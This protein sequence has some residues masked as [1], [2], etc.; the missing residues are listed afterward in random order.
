MD[1][2]TIL[3]I[4]VVMALDAFAVSIAKGITVQDERMWSAF[5]L[6]SLFGGL[7][8]LMPLLGWL[9]GLGFRDA[10]MEID[11][12]IAFLL[13]ARIGA[14]MI[15]DAFKGDND[16]GG[17][18]TVP[19]A[20]SPVM[21]TT[22]DALIVGLSFAF[23]EDSIILPIVIIGVVT[24]LLSFVGFIFARTLEKAFGGRIKMRGG[25]I[26]I[27]IVS[28]YLSIACYDGR[29]DLLNTII[30]RCGRLERPSTIV[31]KLRGRTSSSYIPLHGTLH[32]FGT[33]NKYH[34]LIN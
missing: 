7:L 28:R 32:L 14:K 15:W 8:A 26:L 6:A 19:L 21:A 25:A 9:S 20:L 22:I 31:R 5:L 29:S 27:M 30:A 11:H 10:I 4:A 23:L 12:W 33:R 2:L 18:L 17:G 1:L 3:L 34:H 13:L 16:E 24:L